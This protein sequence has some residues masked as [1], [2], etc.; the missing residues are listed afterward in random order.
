MFAANG[1]IS[2]GTPMHRIA[3]RDPHRG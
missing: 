2:I 1:Y 3:V